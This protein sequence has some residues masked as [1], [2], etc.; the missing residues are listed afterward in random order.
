MTSANGGN[1][2]GT[3]AFTDN[4]NPIENCSAVQLSPH[5]GGGSAAQCPTSTL[6]AGSHAI[7]ATYGGDS[8]FGPGN[9]SLQYTVTKATT[10]TAITAIEPPSSSFLQ[11]VTFT[12]LV[13]GAFGGSPSGSVV[14]Q[15]VTN[16]TPVPICTGTLQSNGRRGK[17]LPQGSG[18]TATC[19]STS[20]SV[21]THSIQATYNGDANFGGSTS[22][23]PIS[24]TVTQ[25]VTTTAI[26]AAPPQQSSFEQ[27][28]TFTATVTGANGGS[29]TG[30]AS[31]TDNGASIQGC[32]ALQLSPLVGGGAAATCPTS[33]LAIGQHTIAVSYGGDTNFKSSNTSISYT[34]VKAT[35]TTALSPTVPSVVNQPVTFTATVSAQFPGRHCPPAPWLSPRI[36]RQ[37]SELRPSDA[38]QQQREGPMYDGHIADWL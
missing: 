25:A 1:P 2:T 35:S 26:T 3:V 4:G 34:V 20:L 14:I 30:T 29:P 19:Q 37:Y 15:D 17:H 33:T 7:V 36:E 28:V 23:P 6:T 32:P 22:T 38:E 24:Y 16:G 11:Q 27:P 8:N 10:T 5:Q 21:G 31:F 18:S 9:G 13:A 12:V